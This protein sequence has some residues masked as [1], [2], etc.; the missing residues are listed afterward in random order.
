MMPRVGFIM[1]TR[2]GSRLTHQ[3]AGR[4][5]MDEFAEGVAFCFPVR[6]QTAKGGLVG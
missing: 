5:E 2:Q 6:L 3:L 4:D 1:K